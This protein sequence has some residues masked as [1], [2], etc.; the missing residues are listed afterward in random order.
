MFSGPQPSDTFFYTFIKSLLIKHGVIFTDISFIA[1]T[2]F[3]L[4][5]KW[6]G[7]TEL[8]RAKGRQRSYAYTSEKNW[9]L[10]LCQIQLEKCPEKQKWAKSCRQKNFFKS[11]QEKYRI[12]IIPSKS[13]PLQ[14]IFFVQLFWS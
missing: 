3:L 1:L 4:L 5:H 6:S 13:D 7:L 11:L 14:Q 8:W 9:K 10:F 12:L 2:Y